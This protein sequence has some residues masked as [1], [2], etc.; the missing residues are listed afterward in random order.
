MAR[1]TGVMLLLIGLMGTLTGCP[2][3]IDLVPDAAIVAQPASGRVPLTVHFEGKGFV[4]HE[5]TSGDRIVAYEWDLGN[6][7]TAT[8]KRVTHTYS[9]PGTY[10]V[11]LT[12]TDDD[13]QTDSTR[14]QVDVAPARPE[15]I[16]W[17]NSGGG[18]ILSSALDGSD[19]RTLFDGLSAAV[20][21]GLSVDAEHHKVYWANN[22]SDEIQRA[23]LDGTDQEA[24]LSGVTNPVGVEVDEANDKV[25]WTTQGRPS[26]VRRAD[27]DGSNVETVATLSG[28]GAEVE[29]AP[30]R[31]H[32]YWVDFEANAI[33][34][35][36]LDGS[37]VTDL[38]TGIDDQP[39]GLAL[40][41]VNDRLYYTVALG[42]DSGVKRADLDGDGVEVLVNST[43]EPTGIDLDLANGKVYWT[44]WAANKFR[45]ADLDGSD[46]EDLVTAGLN[47]PALME[48]GPR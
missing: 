11:K 31:G 36:N 19:V 5:N 41:L 6:G 37:D 34:R 8:G 24:F 20:P 22:G 1:N 47:Q 25:Y 27:L 39:R 40:D 4:S 17:T 3:L 15:R 12:V 35:A 38:I 29:V 30:S 23:D 21:A 42:S 14:R 16:Y 33:Q 44:E 9:T 7:R 46:P 48:L 26:A 45:R 18:E 43:G 28:S 10:T 13:G 2:G 32:V